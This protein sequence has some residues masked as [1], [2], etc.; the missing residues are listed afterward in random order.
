[1]RKTILLAICLSG[2]GFAPVFGQG[3]RT[4]PGQIPGMPLGAN[5]TTPVPALTKF[6]LDFPGGPPELLVKAIE[7]ATGKPLNVII[8]DGDAGTTSLP[9]LKMNNVDVAQ[10]FSALSVASVRSYYVTN[11]NSVSVETSQYQFNTRADNPSDDSIWFFTIVSPHVPPNPNACRF[12][13]LAPYIERGFTVDDIT[14]A[15][16]TA[17]NLTGASAN[18]TANPQLFFH[19]ETSLLIAVA[20]P[21]KLQMVQDALNVLPATRV[22]SNEI[23]E[24]K[25]SIEMLRQQVGELKPMPH[26]PQPVSPH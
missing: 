1:M 9:P 16:H 21:A 18:E 15:I 22:T 20:D 26:F 23:D 11:G 6:N 24:M 14:T 4:I 17:W 10:L 12:Y 2:L 8:Q 5:A 25:K 7:K 3:T 19:K 13:S